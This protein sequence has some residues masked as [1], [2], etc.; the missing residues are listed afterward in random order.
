[1]MGIQQL[2]RQKLLRP[3]DNSRVSVQKHINGGAIVNIEPDAVRFIEL[4][5]DNAIGMA[6]ALFEAA[7]VTVQELINRLDAAKK[8][9]AAR[10]Q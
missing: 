7:G 9:Y 10:F 2:P 1:M 6:L 4:S 5:R 8:E 3:G